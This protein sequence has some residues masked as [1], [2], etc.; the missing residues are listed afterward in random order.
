M[1]AAADDRENRDSGDDEQQDCQPPADEA[2]L[3]P[4]GEAT[5]KL[6]ENAQPP[7]PGKTIHPRRPIPTPPEKTGDDEK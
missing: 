5:V 1:S 2:K 4:A 6:H 3:K 7:P